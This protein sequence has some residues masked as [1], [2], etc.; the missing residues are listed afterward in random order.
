MAYG[1]SEWADPGL[2][3]CGFL[4]GLVMTSVLVID[5]LRMNFNCS[6]STVMWRV[7]H[8]AAR[9]GWD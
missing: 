9:L 6:A 8:A 2:R 4:G 7:G 3:G 1:Y 5:R